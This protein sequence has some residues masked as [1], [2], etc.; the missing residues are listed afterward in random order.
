M[1]VGNGV[2]HQRPR[3]GTYISPH[4]SSSL[5][6]MACPSKDIAGPSQAQPKHTAA[7]SHQFELADHYFELTIC[8]LPQLHS[9]IAPSAIL[10]SSKGQFAQ[11]T[12]YPFNS[13]L[14][15]RNAS[16]E[17]REAHPDQQE[18]HFVPFPTSSSAAHH[19]LTNS[20]PTPSQNTNTNVQ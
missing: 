15:C 6:F 9:K 7:V 16:H 14:C 17:T 4:P 12:S 1:S 19:I 2:C 3:A 18:G 13:G 5:Q 20:T 10:V 11:D 8:C